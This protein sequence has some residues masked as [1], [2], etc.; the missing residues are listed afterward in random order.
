M[1]ILR[2]IRIFNGCEVRI[3][4]SVT[5]VTVLHHEACRFPIRA[6]QPLL[7]PFLAFTSFNN[8]IYDYTRVILSVLRQLSTYSVKKYLVRLRT[9]TLATEHFAENDVKTDVVTSKIHL[10]SCTRVVLHTLM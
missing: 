7:V 1:P 5:M 6:E 3:E 8:S 9:L 2:N 10:T 4:N